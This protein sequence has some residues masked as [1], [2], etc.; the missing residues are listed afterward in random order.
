MNVTKAAAM[1][2]IY[3]KISSGLLKE[4]GG[5]FLPNPDGP[6]ES[7]CVPAGSFRTLI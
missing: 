4:P 6:G 7:A 1:S 3:R 5:F 2:I